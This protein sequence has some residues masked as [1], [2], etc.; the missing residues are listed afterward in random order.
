AALAHVQMARLSALTEDDIAGARLHCEAAL[1]LL[2]DQPDAL[3][4]LGD[5]C[6]RAGEHLRALKA[7]DRLREVGLGRHELDRVGRAHLLAGQGWET[8]LN[9]PEKAL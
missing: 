1:K 2:P 6:H 9:Q 8:G 4:L 5:L 7:L 3:Y